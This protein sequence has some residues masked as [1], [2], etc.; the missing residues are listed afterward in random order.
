MQPWK[1]YIYSEC[2]DESHEKQTQW[3]GVKGTV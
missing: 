1:A 3:D 2:G